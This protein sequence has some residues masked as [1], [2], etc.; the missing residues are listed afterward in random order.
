MLRNETRVWCGPR[1]SALLLRDDF[2]R[3]ERILLERFGVLQARRVE[4]LDALNEA[5]HTLFGLDRFLV[6]QRILLLGFGVLQAGRV[7]SLD[8]LDHAAL[9]LLALDVGGRRQHVLLL[10]VRLRQRLRAERLE[11]GLEVGGDAR[12]RGG[13]G[14]LSGGFHLVFLRGVCAATKVVSVFGEVSRLGA[15]I[16]FRW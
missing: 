14:F 1:L 3:R 2:G 15:A 10:R 8:A 11:L 4:R 16:W 7:E 12:V 13:G 5:L 9:R 6:R